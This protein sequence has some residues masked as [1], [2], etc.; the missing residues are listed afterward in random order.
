MAVSALES[1]SRWEEN[2]NLFMLST[3]YISNRAENTFYHS[4][5]SYDQF[6]ETRTLITS[7]LYWSC[8]NYSPTL[9]P[10]ALSFSASCSGALIWELDYER[11]YIC[12]QYHI[13]SLLT[14]CLNDSFHGN[15]YQMHKRQGS[16][17][18]WVGN[19]PLLVE[20]LDNL[21]FSVHQPSPGQLV[22][23]EIPSWMWRFT[24]TRA[25]LSASTSGSSSRFI[26]IR[27]AIEGAIETGFIWEN[28]ACNLE[29][30][31]FRDW[32]AVALVIDA[33]C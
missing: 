3:S 32:L 19:S 25:V 17:R 22:G 11:V 13:R 14:I 29:W 27:G 21:L 18:C 4:E 26:G 33:P 12:H 24:T 30:P 2:R 1:K 28:C 20:P 31:L 16:S 8:C 15:D 5:I 7:S 6:R 23:G 9:Y 10:P